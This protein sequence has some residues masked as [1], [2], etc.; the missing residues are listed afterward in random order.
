M[1]KML[2]LISYAQKGRISFLRI[3]MRP[4][5]TKTKKRPSE[6]SAKTQNCTKIWQQPQN[7]RSSGTENCNEIPAKPN[8]RT[9]NC[10]KPRNRTSLWCRA[11]IPDFFICLVFF[12]SIGSDTLFLIPFLVH[13]IWHLFLSLF[14]VQAAFWLAHWDHSERTPA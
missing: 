9:K 5:I 2:Y 11:S 12:S 14:R 8:N 10:V 13:Q 6:I 1:E 3:W 7:V 4:E